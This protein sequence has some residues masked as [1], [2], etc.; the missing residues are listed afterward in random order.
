MWLL[1]NLKVLMWLALILSDSALPD[2]ALPGSEVW[3]A[4]LCFYSREFLGSSGLRVLFRQTR[5]LESFTSKGS[6]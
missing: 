3:T 2:S 5:M 1:E 4:A 6:L